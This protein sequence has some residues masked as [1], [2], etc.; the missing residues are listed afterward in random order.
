MPGS[1]G[2]AWRRCARGPESA[3]ARHRPDRGDG[4]VGSIQTNA[5]ARRLIEPLQDLAQSTGIT[6]MLV[7]HTIK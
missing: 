7:T 4:R 6:V 3:A 1:C 5:G 2:N